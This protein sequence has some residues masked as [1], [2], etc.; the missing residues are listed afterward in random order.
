MP[1]LSPEMSGALLAALLATSAAAAE[2]SRVYTP[3]PQPAPA[4]PPTTPELVDLGGRVYRGACQGCHGEKGDG[5]GREGKFLAIPPRDFTT[6]QFIIRSTPLGSLPLDAD[7]FGSIRRGFVP[8]QGMPGFAFLSDREVWGVVA[9]LKTLSP[10]WKDEK[11]QKAVELPAPPKRTPELEAAGKAVF[12]G[13]GACFLCHGM[14][15]QGDGPVAPGLAYTSGAHKGK[16][17]K[18]ANLT[19]RQDFKGGGRAEDIYRSISTGLDGTP[20]P[21][22]ATLSPEQRWQLTFFILSLSPTP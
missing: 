7:L 10:R 12:M 11:P 4:Q 14:A 16:R 5:L 1:H 3:W 17:V 19:R 18:P 6:A 15:G 20:M 22:F 8:G 21:A 2:P 9:Y 13:A